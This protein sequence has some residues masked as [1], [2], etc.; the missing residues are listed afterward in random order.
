MNIQGTYETN[1]GAMKIENHGDHII[2][3]YAEN[4]I[5]KGTLTKNVF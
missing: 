2:G 5:L 4:G 3:K 1:N